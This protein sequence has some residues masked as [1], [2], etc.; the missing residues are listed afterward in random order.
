MHPKEVVGDQKPT[1]LR[2]KELMNAL[3][4]AAS[5]TKLVNKTHHECRRFKL[6]NIDFFLQ[7]YI[8]E[9]QKY[10]QKGERT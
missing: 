8:E 4:F 1:K 10:T 5:R 7:Y 2:K 6:R 9:A 3:F